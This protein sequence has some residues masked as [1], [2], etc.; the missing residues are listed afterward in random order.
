MISSFRF[1]RLP[2]IVFGEGRLSQLPGIAR[3]YG[4]TLLLVTGRRSFAGSPAAEELLPRLKEMGMEVRVV[5]VPGEPSASFID[6]AVQSLRGVPVSVVVAIGGGS[7]L[8]A[9]KALSAMLGKQESVVGYIEGVGNRE[10]PGTKIPFVAVPTTAGTGSEA[11]KNAVLSGSPQNPFKRSLRHDLFVPEVALVDPRLAVSAPRSVTIASGMDCFVQLTESFLSPAASPFTDALALE[12]LKAVKESLVR[13]VGDGGDLAARTGMALAAL[14]S[15]ICLAN[16]GL[17]VIH[18]FASSLGGMFSIPHG[19]ICGTLMAEAVAV[20][21]QALRQASADGNAPQN[22]VPDGA[23][24]PAADC[25][26]GLRKIARLGRL[27]VGTENQSD[28]Y[29]R[30]GFVEYLRQLTLQM[31]LPRLGEY[32]VGRESLERVCAATAAKNNPVAL[33]R[34]A[35][36]EI[37]I[38]RI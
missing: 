35:L 26:T 37:L 30:D 14:T 25:E 31:G 36:M 17:G 32:G 24:S 4:D 38:R 9:G 15:G 33:R 29:C 2:E 22:A 12:G 20:N 28:E 3:R 19:V 34:E 11:T 8:D 16:A 6:D 1:A 18:G 10:H 13:V 21:L 23:A 7:A 5:A 27:F